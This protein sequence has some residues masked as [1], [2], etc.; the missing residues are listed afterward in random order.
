MR[1]DPVSLK[2]FVSVVE[3]GTIAAA[4]AREHIAA[5]ALSRRLADLEGVLRTRLLDRTN[6]GV[7]P[8]AAGITLV[9]LARRALHELDDIAVQM[10]DYASGVRGHVR[11][12]ANIS[13][14]TQF[15]PGEIKGFRERYPQVQIHLEE[16]ISSVVTRA[17][18]DNAADLGIYTAGP[19]AIE[20]ETFP[21]HADRLVL[22]A[23]K[24][25]PLADCR[26]LAFAD[27]LDFDYVGLHTGSAINLQ[28]TKAAS[29]ID[30]T[31]RLAI[32][33]TSYD[34]LCV[35]V[36]AGLGIGLLPEALARLHARMLGIR[37]IRLTDAW[38]ER[39]L[40]I[41]VRAFDALPVAAR[42]LVCHLRQG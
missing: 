30:R 24:D 5:A 14:I 37:A 25:H 26:R 40:R 9:N 20:L 12:F 31:V 3:E 18:A 28:L 1:L 41:C 23:P 19:H 35:M 33:V 13:A 16:K 32:Q 42:L 10:A 6:K 11:M 22:I 8:T 29:E 2:L 4:A 7:E 39:E 38:A 15:L 17:V 27:T 36:G 21:Y 34:A